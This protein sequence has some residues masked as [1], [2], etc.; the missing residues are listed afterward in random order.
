MNDKTRV[1]FRKWSNG[2]VLALFPELDAGDY[3][4][5]SYMHVGQHGGADYIGCVAQTTL[6]TPDEYQP[7]AVELA[8]IGYDLDIKQRR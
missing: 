8:S 7:L 5:D 6:A 1:I 4:C 2:D 3:L